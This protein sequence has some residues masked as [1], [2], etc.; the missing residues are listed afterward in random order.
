MHSQRY[1]GFDQMCAEGS[2]RPRE[3]K[4]VVPAS[5]KTA[6]ATSQR[7]EALVEASGG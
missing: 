6:Q 1:E 2:R 4:L 5:S 7:A 3:W